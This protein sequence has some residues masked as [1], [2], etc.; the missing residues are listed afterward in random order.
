MLSLSKRVPR[1]LVT[2]FV[3]LFVER[4]GSTFLITAL[5]SHPS[6]LARTEILAALRESGKTSAEQLK[7]TQSFLTPPLVGC[8]KAIGFKSKLPDVLDRDSFTELLRRRRVRIIK[9]QR[10]NSVKAVVS[11]LNARRQ[12]EA[13]GNWNLLSEATRLPSFKVDPD[14]FD[15][16]LREREDLNRDLEEYVRDLRL[17][18]LTLYYEDLLAD[19]DGFINRSLSFIG[20]PAQP[21]EAATLKNTQDNLREAVVNFD[22]LRARYA[23]THYEPMF[24]DGIVTV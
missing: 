22:E 2:R 20:V 17:P 6:V 19:R 21:L 11:S 4:A 9:L 8:H 14:E 5:K 7:W 3:I 23:G 18:T 13:S 16:L 10:K 12:W 15:G 1:F 24:D